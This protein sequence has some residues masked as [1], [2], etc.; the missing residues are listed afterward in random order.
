M[1]RLEP[2]LP[3]TGAGRGTTPQRDAGRPGLRKM[4]KKKRKTVLSRAG[5]LW[6]M[7]MVY[8]AVSE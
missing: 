3:V 2:S 7:I 5:A 4:V 6:I 1:N 8:C